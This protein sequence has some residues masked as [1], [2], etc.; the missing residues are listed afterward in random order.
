MK[1][2]NVNTI[3][4]LVDMSGSQIKDPVEMANKFNHFFTS[5]ANNTTKNIPRNPRS[6]LSY[7]AN[8]NPNSFFMC[9]CTTNKVS[10]V[11]KSLKNGKSSGPNSIPIKLLKI[12]DR[13][14]S[15]HLSM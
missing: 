15:A 1:P 6:A 3:A 8:P 4:H 9:A 11:I 13:Y 5:F 7:L 2:N 12:L 14:F 10:D